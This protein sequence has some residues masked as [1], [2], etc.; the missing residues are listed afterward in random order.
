M[1]DE[2]E[3]QHTSQKYIFDVIVPDQKSTCEKEYVNLMR[4][5]KHFM[6]NVVN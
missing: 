6:F 5:W 2:N 1:I 3:N 4:I